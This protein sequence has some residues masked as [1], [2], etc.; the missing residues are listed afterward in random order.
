MKPYTRYFWKELTDDGRFID[1]HWATTGGY[2]HSDQAVVHFHMKFSV[3]P[4]AGD[5][6]SGPKYQLIK[7]YGIA[8]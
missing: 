3:D 7:L 1:A 4:Y 2:E 6:A 8:P 5:L